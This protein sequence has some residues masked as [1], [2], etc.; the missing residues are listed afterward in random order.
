[1]A[2][3]ILDKINDNASKLKAKYGICPHDLTITYAKWDKTKWDKAKTWEM[4]KAG[5][6]KDQAKLGFFW[7]RGKGKNGPITLISVKLDQDCGKEL[8]TWTRKKNITSG[9]FITDVLNKALPDLSQY[10]AISVSILDYSNARDGFKIFSQGSFSYRFSA[11]RGGMK[12]E[13][14]ISEYKYSPSKTRKP[15]FLLGEELKKSSI[16]KSF[17]ENT[18]KLTVFEHVAA[19][20]SSGK[21]LNVDLQGFRITRGIYEDH[22]QMFNFE[23]KASNSIGDISTAINQAINYKE[24]ANFTYIAIPMFDYENFHDSDRFEGLLEICRRNQIGIISV[25]MDPAKHVIIDLIEVLRAEETELIDSSD[26]QG[27]LDEYEYE[28]CPLCRKI[29]QSSQRSMCGWKVGDENKCMKEL[30]GDNMVKCATIDP[31]A[32]IEDKIDKLCQSKPSGDDGK[33]GEARR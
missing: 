23:L 21:F 6:I 14:K 16:S 18:L 32:I 28:K 29:V 4:F 3:T 15:E 2:K 17:F 30:M 9:D 10:L 25:R 12:F 11:G 13:W 8:A 27:M 33:A 22:F 1:M 31:V 19:A 24:R 5:F 26:L 7:K 20:R